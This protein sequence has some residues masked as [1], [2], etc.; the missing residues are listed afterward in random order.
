MGWQHLA[1]K[2]S[3]G[4]ARRYIGYILASSLAVMVFF[5]FTSF[6]NNPHVTH[7]YMTE[8]AKALL[9]ACRYLVAVFAVFFI[10]FFHAHLIRLRNREFGLLIVLGMTPRQIGRMIRFESVWIGIMAMG[11][12]IA[13]GT[14]FLKLFLMALGTILHL[15]DPIPFLVPKQAVWYTLA[16]FGIVFVLDAIFIAIRVRFRSAHSL[17]LGTRTHQTPPKARLWLVLLGCLCIATGYYMAVAKSREFVTNVIPILLLTCIGTYLLFTHT[18]VFVFTRFRKRSLHGKT[19]LLVSRLAYRIKDYARMLTVVTLLTAM[20]LTGMGTMFSVR[21]I[22]NENAIRTDPYS[23]QFSDLSTN[24]LPVQPEQVRQVVQS[25]NLSIQKEIEVEGLIGTLAG[26]YSTTLKRISGGQPEP[27]SVRILSY[28]QYESL[29]KTLYDSYPDLRNYLK[30]DPPLTKGNAHFYFPYPDDLGED[31]FQDPHVELQ[32]GSLSIPLTIDGEKKTRVLNQSRNGIPEFL[33]VVQ[34]ALY[35]E[36]AKQAGASSKWYSY[37]WI[38][39]DWEASRPAVESL[40]SMVPNGRFGTLTST[41]MPYVDALQLLSVMLVAGFFVS[42]LFLLACGTTV[43]F[44][45]FSQ[46]EEDI[47][48]FHVL[49]R[50]GLRKKEAG[51]VLARE[52]SLFFFVPFAVA[53]IHSLFAM[54]D[55]Q[56]LLTVEGSVWAPFGLVVA[57]CFFFYLLYYVVSRIRYL[58]QMRLD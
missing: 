48:Q 5:L 10:Y 49:Q 4:N 46:L 15:V 8:K 39:N 42:V 37:G 24:P 27:Q 55:L 25:Y 47:R 21:W 41:V 18:L 23:V 16:F 35:Q 52:F 12:G 34:D 9:N 7:G 30:P 43:Y 11:I 51:A 20:V 17:I 19:L 3:F 33:L 58:R 28:S 57:I 13:L 54:L 22:Y 26:S 32:F 56:H 2:N 38:L 45:M 50:I 31:V 1:F 14:L 29:R 6:V 44:R 53:L 40:Q 36:L